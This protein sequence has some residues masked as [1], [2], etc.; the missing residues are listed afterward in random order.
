MLRQALEHADF[1]AVRAEYEDLFIGVGKSPVTLYT[2]H[3]AVSHAP[4]RHLLALR[5]Y[6]E[7][8]GLRRSEQ[9]VE[10]ED[11]ISALCDVMRW[12]IESGADGGEQ[13]RFF[14]VFLSPAVRGLRDAIAT[15]ETASFY[16]TVA[17]FACAFFEVEEQAFGMA[18]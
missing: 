4:D 3:Y 18:L 9:A 13:Q 17:N 16:R 1:D 6:L 11:H 12:L 2:S 10:T 7:A 14:E 8:S 15:A 5:Q